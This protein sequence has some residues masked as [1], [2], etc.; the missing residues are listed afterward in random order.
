[1][2]ALPLWQISRQ[3]SLSDVFPY[4]HVPLKDFVP[5]WAFATGCIFVQSQAGNSPD[6]LAFW[7]F[8]KYCPAGAMQCHKT[9]ASYD[10]VSFLFQ[11]DHYP[12][13]DFPRKIVQACRRHDY[14]LIRMSFFVLTLN[15]VL[16]RF[17]GL[18]LSY[19]PGSLSQTLVNVKC[20]IKAY[21]FGRL[22]SFPIMFCYV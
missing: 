19:L 20:A 11:R 10:R 1:M 15:Y 3:G 4:S 13:K 16:D 18:F 21:A 8:D 2:I 6:I 17:F 7:Q 5:I 9:K 14:I 12:L 22:F